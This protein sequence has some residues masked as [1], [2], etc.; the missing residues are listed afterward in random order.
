MDPSEVMFKNGRDDVL[1][2]RVFIE[3]VV[4]LR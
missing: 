2:E 3:A 1:Y 4:S